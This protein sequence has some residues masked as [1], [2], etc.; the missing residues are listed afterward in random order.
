MEISQLLLEYL[1]GKDFLPATKIAQG[2]NQ[3]YWKVVREL[4]TMERNKLVVRRQ[5][6][7]FSYWKLK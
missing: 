7:V 5:E 4:E 6:Q 3:G 1:K 2:I